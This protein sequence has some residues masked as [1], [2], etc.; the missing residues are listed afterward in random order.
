[1]VADPRRLTAAGTRPR[2]LLDW[3]GA[4]RELAG[5][6]RRTRFDRMTGC[7][8]ARWVARIEEI[9][10]GPGPLPAPTVMSSF[11]DGLLDAN[12]VIALARWS[13]AR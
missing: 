7:D 11:E 2:S 9:L 13:V 6:M 12:D 10:D 3:P 1:M 4:L 8:L 5:D